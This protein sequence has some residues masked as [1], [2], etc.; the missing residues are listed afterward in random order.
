ME[1]VAPRAALVGASS[2]AN[3]RGLARVDAGMR[4]TSFVA[5]ALGALGALGALVGCSGGGGA[6]VD[7]GPDAVVVD[8]GPDAASVVDTGAVYLADCKLFNRRCEGPNA[9]DPDC[10]TCQYRV[11]YRADACSAAAPCDQLLLYWAAFD[12]DHPGLAAATTELLTTHPRTVILCAQPI[13]PGEILPTTLGAPERD[14]R[15]VTAALARLR[16]GGDLGVWSGADLLFAGCSMGAT[17]YPVV[18][19]RYADD[20]G[21]LGSRKTAVC[22]SE[23]VVDIAAQ[24][25]FIGPGTGTSCA[26]R[27]GRV[28]HGYTRAVPMTGHACTDSPGGQCACDPAH[29]ALTY[30]GDC[31]GGDCVAF[32][33]I[34]ATADR[35]FAPGVTADS[36]AVEHWKLV[37]EGERWRDDLANRCERDVVP[38]APLT[39]L[40]AL[41]DA[42][43]DHDCAIVHVPDA[44]HCSY[45]ND[46]LGRECLD[47][48][49]ALAP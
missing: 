11:R 4:G 21:W 10:G 2:A 14:D 12:C 32:D 28:V 5:C 49:T 47:W 25:A 30:P 34:V 33:S 46:N 18:A 17:R 3:L 9:A 48:F 42:D 29:T 35:Q 19:A 38:A 16:P 31:G 13:F 6:A 23:G 45:F 8:A 24:D 36:F 15:V 43:D 44:P 27:H 1:G 39:T 26:G 7:A 41:L 22:M 40:C 37:T 20:A